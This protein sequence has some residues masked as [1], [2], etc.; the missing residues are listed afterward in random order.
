MKGEILSLE[1]AKEIQDLRSRLD[2]ALKYIQK[3]SIALGSFDKIQLIKILRGTDNG[4]HTESC[5]SRYYKTIN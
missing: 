4:R 2:K 5:N 1:T 3:D